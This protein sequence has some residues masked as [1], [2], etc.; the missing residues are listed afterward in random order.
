MWALLNRKH[1]TYAG[2]SSAAGWYEVA[3]HMTIGGHLSAI[4]H[5][6]TGSAARL[7]E[8]SWR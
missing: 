6:P 2:L 3:H 1:G 7:R 4:G 5:L 8:G